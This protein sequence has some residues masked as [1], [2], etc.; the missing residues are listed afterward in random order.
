VYRSGLVDIE[1]QSSIVANNFVSS[2]FADIAME[3]AVPISGTNNLVVGAQDDLLPPATLRDDPQLLPLGFNGGP[4]QTHAISP[5]SPAR[6]KGD[7][8][9]GLATDQR[10][11]PFV[12][13]Y[14]TAADIGA[15]EYSLP[16]EIFTD[17]FELH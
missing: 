16:N 14:G 8:T 7:N 17:D 1:L 4:T 15:F 3:S 10:G 2:G 9:A 5:T 11:A 13:V 12:R 6:D